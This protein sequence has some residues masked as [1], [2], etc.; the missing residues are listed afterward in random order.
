MIIDTAGIIAQIESGGDPRKTRFENLAY[1]K[2]DAGHAAGTLSPAARGVLQTVTLANGGCSLHTA[3]QIYVT[4]IGKYQFLG[5]T[6]YGMGYSGWV[7]DF[8]ANIALQDRYFAALTADRKIAFT[9]AE[10]RAEPEKRQLFALHYN[11]PGNV[12]DYAARIA[13]EI[14]RQ[15][16]LTP[17]Q[18]A[19]P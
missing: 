11:G 19:P 16:A 4:S 7:H 9:V 18:G 3:L 8:Q 12:D 10:L 2:L 17:G 1:A 6:L 15:D 14:A 5:E 13:A